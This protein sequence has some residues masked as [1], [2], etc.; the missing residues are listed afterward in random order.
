MPT[1]KIYCVDKNK[2]ASFSNGSVCL[3]M[4]EILKYEMNFSRTNLYLC[5]CIILR[6]RSCVKSELDHGTRKKNYEFKKANPFRNV[7]QYIICIIN[8][9][10]YKLRIALAIVN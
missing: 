8:T 4:G 6:T 9:V 3:L 5:V 1:H 7:C 10:Q 2:Y